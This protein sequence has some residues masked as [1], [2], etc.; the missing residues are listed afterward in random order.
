MESFNIIRKLGSG[1]YGNV[2][3]V[4][5]DGKF[6]ALKVIENDGKEGIKSLREVDIMGKL[7]HPN[8]MVSEKIMSEYDGQKSKL[9]ILMDKAEFDLHKVMHNDSF[10]VNEKLKILKGVT[11]G[12][13]YLHKNDYLH[14]DLKPINILIF[15]D[16]VSKITDFG[17]SIR[18]EEH[19]N[20][21]EHRNQKYKYYP[22]KLATVDHR[23]I[24]V[25]DGNLNYTV[26]SDIWSLGII[27]IEIL[28]RTLF[29]GFKSEDYTE[30]NV[31]KIYLEKLSSNVIKTTLY[32]YFTG[33]NEPL[34][35]EAINLVSRMLDF[36]PKKRPT[37]DE[38]LASPLFRGIPSASLRYEVKEISI[39]KGECSKADYEGFDVLARIATRIAMGL[40]TFFLAADIYQRILPFRN[41][42][43]DIPED[44]KNVVYTAALAIYM[45]I[46]ML[47][48]YFADTVKIAEL[49]GNLFQPEKLILGESVI[50]NNWNGIIYTDN[51]FTKSSTL[52]RLNEAFNL[53][54]NCFIYRKIDLDA[55]KQFNNEEEKIEG[56]FEKYIPF[57][58]FFLQTPYYSLITDDKD[59]QLEYIT[60][61]Y[62]KDRANV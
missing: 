41:R 47:E 53:A 20:H 42:S 51:L 7:R 3:E 27:F 23:P 26:K 21:E 34:R 9:G 11:Q 46:K 36:D 29:S 40:E 61:L 13:N 39:G 19:G 18:L 60:K 12:L 54:R 57:N 52:K 56:K 38:V 33:L 31:K 30:E 22:V 10:S 59:F 43:K 17:L 62:T 58:D 4:E 8:L 32:R 5:K 14:L 48:G 44:Y 2:Y 50:V 16:N 45:A 1:S 24:E 55:W 37:T 49:A 28:G 25:L 15:K 35:T 6:Y